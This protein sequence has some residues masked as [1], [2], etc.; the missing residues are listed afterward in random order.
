MH[1]L[2]V[3]GYQRVP[4]E[5]I[6][7]LGNQPVSAGVRKPA[8][9]WHDVG[10]QLH[11][12]VH[13]ALPVCVILAAACFEIEKSAGDIRHRDVAVVFVFE[14]MQTA[15]AAAVAQR[16]PLGGRHLVQT[17]AFPER[18]AH[19]ATNRKTTDAAD[20]ITPGFV[21]EYAF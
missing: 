7:S 12:V 19:P 2:R 21:P 14:L 18:K 8:K 17:L 3:S 9:R 4:I 10:R 6:P 1:G 11:A 5:K 13:I 15:F 20:P 16:F